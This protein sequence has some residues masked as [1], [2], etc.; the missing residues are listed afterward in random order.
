MPGS[1]VHLAFFDT[2]GRIEPRGRLVGR[3]EERV[4]MPLLDDCGHMI[5]PKRCRHPEPAFTA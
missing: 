1:P 2:E 4:T 5:D 3:P